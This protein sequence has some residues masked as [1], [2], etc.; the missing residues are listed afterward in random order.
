MSDLADQKRFSTAQAR[1]AIHLIE[2]RQTNDGFVATKWALTRHFCSLDSL[3]QWVSDIAK[4]HQSS[5][6]HQDA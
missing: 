6:E 5:K 2:V 1:A 4:Q 3:E